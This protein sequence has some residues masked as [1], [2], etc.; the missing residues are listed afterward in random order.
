MDSFH[1][2]LIYLAFLLVSVHFVNV[3]QEREAHMQKEISSI[4]S[5]NQVISATEDENLSVNIFQNKQTQI[6]TKAFRRSKSSLS[7]KLYSFTDLSDSRFYFIYKK[8]VESRNLA[9]LNQPH[10]DYYLHTLNRLRI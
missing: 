7:R 8:T 6:N 2:H 10:S 3:G 1:R 5:Q 9:I 4:I